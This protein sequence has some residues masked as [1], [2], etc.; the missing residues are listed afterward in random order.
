MIINLDIDTNMFISLNTNINIIGMKLLLKFMTV[1]YAK[2]NK[3][4]RDFLPIKYFPK[5]HYV[6]CII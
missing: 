1:H 4:L 2:Y 5:L 6:E 3:I